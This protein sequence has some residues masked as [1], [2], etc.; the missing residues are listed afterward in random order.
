MSAWSRVS[1]MVGALAAVGAIV[2][3]GCG[4]GDDRYYCDDS[5]CYSCDGYG[6]RGV[7]APSTTPCTGTSNCAGGSICTVQG[8]AATCNQ[9]SDCPKGTVCTSNVCVA[10][11]STGTVKECTTAA[12]CTGGNVC[13]GNKCV[14]APDAGPDAAPQCTKGSDC[15]SAQACVQGKCQTCGGANGPCACSVTS[16]CNSPNV[17]A[18][19]VCTPATDTCKY[20]SDCGGGICIDGKCETACGPNNTC[21]T[22]YTCIKGGC[23]KNPTG[24]TC[25]K[26]T[27]CTSPTTPYCVGGQCVA[28]CSTDPECGQGN[29]CNQGACAPDTRP[30]GNCQNDN[31]CTGGPGQKCIGGI[32]KYP[33]GDDN[34]CKLIDVR[35][36]YCGMDKVC[37]SF[38]EAHP[39]CTGKSECANGQDCVSNVCR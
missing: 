12:E 20:S 30:Q 13:V 26:S 17:C 25:T 1:A 21:A 11:G 38:E 33:C 23:E 4:T 8:C 14:P 32:C 3:S 10:P 22:G 34:A 36:G 27:D 29:Y 35:I 2:W 9:S 31:Q 28:K 6:C 24:S 7:Q 16:D 18:S 39:Q 15:T 5:G 19:G 37:R